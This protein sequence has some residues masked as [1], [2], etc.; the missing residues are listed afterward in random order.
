VMMCGFGWFVTALPLTI[1]A[2]V[3]AYMLVWMVILDVIKLAIYRHM[4]MGDARPAWYS[5]FLR[6]RH[7]AHIV[8][9]NTSVTK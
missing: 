5:R 2:L 4:N 7:A 3:W 9:E 8:A 6:G 1:I